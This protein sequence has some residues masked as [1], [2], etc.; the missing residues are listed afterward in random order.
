MSNLPARISNVTQNPFARTTIVG[1]GL[2]AAIVG[3]AKLVN[4]IVR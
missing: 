1:V 2:M 4:K 3:V